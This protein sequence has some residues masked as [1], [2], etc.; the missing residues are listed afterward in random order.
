MYM[1]STACLL[2]YYVLLH[3]TLS[4]DYYYYYSDEL[5]ELSQEKLV[6]LMH[7]Q[8]QPMVTQC[9]Q[10]TVTKL[11]SPSIHSILETHILALLS[12]GGANHATNTTNNNKNTSFI[13]Q[14]KQLFIEETENF[15]QFL[16]HP[17][18]LLINNNHHTTNNNTDSDN[19][20][21]NNSNNMEGIMKEMSL[22]SNFLQYFLPMKNPS[23]FR[24]NSLFSLFSY[25]RVYLLQWRLSWTMMIISSIIRSYVELLLKHGSGTVSSSSYHS[26]SN[27]NNNHHHHHFDV[28]TIN[29]LN[30]DL[31]QLATLIEECRLMMIT[32]GPPTTTTTTTTNNNNNNNNNNTV[33]DERD[34]MR[35]TQ[36]NNNNNNHKSKLLLL[37]DN[38]IKQMNNY[39]SKQSFDDI[40]SPLSHLIFAIQMDKYYLLSFVKETLYLDFG[41][42]C[43]KIWIL[44][45]QFRGETKEQIQIDYDKHFKYWK[46]L[47][48]IPGSREGSGSEI[49]TPKMNVSFVNKI[50]A[51]NIIKIQ[52]PSSSASNDCAEDK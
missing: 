32:I 39:A 8:Q 46:P 26:H 43:I 18:Y 50:A 41:I 27:N 2:F 44:I 23:F 47:A 20:N 31:Q 30:D 17:Q 9:L 33:Y 45:E 34:D 28:N 6:L 49:I 19:N 3:S 48:G 21:N 29:Q 40:L 5:L 15:F 36:N 1:N 52:L 11:L 42:L 37:L 25:S 22:H 16:F 7:Q 13:I 38:E 10:Y 14:I 24:A 35:D 12:T 4:E 51:A